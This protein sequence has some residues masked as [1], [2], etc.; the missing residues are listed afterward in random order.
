MDDG[1]Q[2]QEQDE[3]Q[4]FLWSSLQNLRGFISAELFQQAERELGLTPAQH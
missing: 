3:L 4:S 1:R 2:Q